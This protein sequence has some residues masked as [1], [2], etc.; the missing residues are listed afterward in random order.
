MLSFFFWQHTLALFSPTPS[1]LFTPHALSQIGK[2]YSTG[3]LL[4]GEVKAKL[5]EVLAPMVLEHQAQR[6]KVTEEVVIHFMS[7]RPL[8]F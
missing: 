4:T 6:T 2:D 5:V 7:V 8:E 1:I 3:K